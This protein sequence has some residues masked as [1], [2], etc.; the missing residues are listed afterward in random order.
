MNACAGY[1]YLDSRDGTEPTPEWAAGA[2][3]ARF[4]EGRVAVGIV[5]LIQM[6]GRR[7]GCVVEI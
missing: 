1:A 7:R 4:V 6:K 3:A 5:G 2:R